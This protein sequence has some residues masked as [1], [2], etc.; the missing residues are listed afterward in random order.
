M[1]T[2]RHLLPRYDPDE[3]AKY[4]GR[5]HSIDSMELA[6]KITGMIRRGAGEDFLQA[7]FE[8]G[9]LGFLESYHD[10]KGFSLTDKKIVFPEDDNFEGIDF[11]YAHFSHCVLENAVFPQ[12]SFNFADVYGCEFKKCIF[13]FSSFYGA[14]L[15][16]V[17]FVDCEFVERNSFVNCHF[18]DVEFSGCHFSRPVFSDCKFNETTEVGDPVP[19]PTRMKNHPAFSPKQL[20]EFL[21]DVKE[22]FR[23]GGVATKAREYFFRERQAVTRN[24]VAGR[25]NRLAG[26]V[27]E[28]V[29]G[30]GVRP[31]RVLSSLAGVFTASFLFFLSKL[32]AVDAFILASGALFTFGANVDLLKAHGFMFKAAYVIT[33]FSG[34]SLTAL[35]VT[36]WANVWLREQ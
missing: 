10:L 28:W 26:Y 1:Y 32:E 16:K 9:R 35:L 18:Q 13:A 8:G 17:Q 30:Y 23:N 36:V 15:E 25:W 4:T 24:N 6:D 22:G 7:D 27:M 29:A 33:S 20:A 2:P 31:W 3:Q 11:S 19:A 21:K 5:W 34:I 12:S 14:S